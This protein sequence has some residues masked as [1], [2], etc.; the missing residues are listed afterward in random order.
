M[1]L[2]Q[3]SKA[4]N[5]QNINQLLLD[6]VIVIT[7]IVITKKTRAGVQLSKYMLL[8]YNKF[9]NNTNINMRNQI[10]W[11]MRIFITINQHINHYS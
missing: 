8:F 2:I 11:N 4:N 7:D 1:Q 3:K 6:Y 9:K 5:L 10:T